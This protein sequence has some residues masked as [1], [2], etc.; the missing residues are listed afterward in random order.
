MNIYIVISC[1]FKMLVDIHNLNS[2]I[3][4]YYIYFPFLKYTHGKI[5]NMIINGMQ[6]KDIF[7]ELAISIQNLLDGKINYNDLVMKRRKGKIENYGENNYIRIFIE[8]YGDL[9][10]NVKMIKYI[11]VSKPNE[12]L[13]GNRMIPYHIFLQ[14]LDTN[15]AYNVDYKFYLDKLQYTIDKLIKVACIMDI[16]ENISYPLNRYQRLFLNQ[17]V[18]LI[19]KYLLTHESLHSIIDLTYEFKIITLEYYLPINI[20]TYMPKFYLLNNLH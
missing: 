15:N 10:K 9:F 14:S 6:I 8:K 20:N 7:I 18:K 12:R 5:Y 17:P 16:P 4:K 2:K 3:Q 19:N 11:V 13:I 1:L